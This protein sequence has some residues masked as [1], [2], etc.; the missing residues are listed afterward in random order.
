MHPLR[1]RKRFLHD[2]RPDEKREEPNPRLNLRISQMRRCCLSLGILA[3][4]ANLLVL[5]NLSRVEMTG[6][7]NRLP[8]L[9]N[10]CRNPT[11]FNDRHD[12]VRKNPNLA[13]HDLLPKNSLRRPTSARQGGSGHSRLLQPLNLTL[14]FSIPLLHPLN[15]RNRPLLQGHRNRLAPRRFLYDLKRPRAPSHPF[16][17]RRFNQHI[18]TARRPQRHT[19]AVI[20]QLRIKASQRPLTCF[21]KSIRL[22]L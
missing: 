14:T 19:N 20:M 7:I 4:R 17:R 21:P 9:P 3:L 13:C 22:Q 1:S 11:F 12:L 15:Q 16:L 6:A 10:A 2:R 8:Q 18:G 5:L